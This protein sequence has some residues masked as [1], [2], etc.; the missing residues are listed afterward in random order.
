MK[1]WLLQA[2]TDL[3][4]GDDPWNPWYDKTFAMVVRAKDEQHARALAHTAGAD[5]NRGSFLNAKSADTQTPWL[6]DKYSTC[7]PLVARVGPA[8]VLITDHRRG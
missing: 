5:E 1:L 3:P 2:R 4:E 7:E 6:Q 8:G